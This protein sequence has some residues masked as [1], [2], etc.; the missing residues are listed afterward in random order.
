MADVVTIGDDVSD[1][2]TVVH[3]MRFWQP[4]HMSPHARVMPSDSTLYH[5]TARPSGIVLFGDIAV[6]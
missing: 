1:V 2:S 6:M 5:S 3:D 4:T